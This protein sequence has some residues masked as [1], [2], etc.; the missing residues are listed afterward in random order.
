M[1]RKK[2]TVQK[3]TRSQLSHRRDHIIIETAKYA[4]SIYRAR[5]FGMSWTLIADKLA[6]VVP[7]F[8]KERRKARR[9]MDRAIEVAKELETRNVELTQLQIPAMNTL[10]CWDQLG[11]PA[12][13]AS[14]TP[15]VAKSPKSIIADQRSTQSVRPEPIAESTIQ[16]ENQTVEPDVTTVVRRDRAIQNN[17]EKLCAIDAKVLYIDTLTDELPPFSTGS[18][19]VSVFIPESAKISIVAVTSGG[20]M[21]ICACLKTSAYTNAL[22]VD[23]LLERYGPR[24]TGPRLPPIPPTRDRYEMIAW[25]ASPTV[26]SALTEII[27]DEVRDWFESLPISARYPSI[28]TT[29]VRVP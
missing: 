5:E 25:A 13:I 22:N 28:T 19:F 6:E 18:D 8:V 11:E 9:I 27:K 17:V 21:C 3:T 4:E 15:T 16:N 2:A 23:L 1:A 7:G 10:L 12:S 26:Q 14:A 20:R 29:V 24:I